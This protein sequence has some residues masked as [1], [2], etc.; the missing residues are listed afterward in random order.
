[1]VDA[2]SDFRRQWALGRGWTQ[3]EFVRRE[4]AQAS[5]EEKRRAADVVIQNDGTIEKLRDAVCRFWEQN[6]ASG[7]RPIYP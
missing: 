7:K 3:H 6:I 5:V 1:M 4:A 2:P